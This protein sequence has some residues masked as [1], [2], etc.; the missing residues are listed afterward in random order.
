MSKFYP[1][2]QPAHRE[3]ISAQHLFF[4]G[5]AAQDGRV[6]ISP[7]GNDSLRILND[8]QVVWLNHTG[9]GNETSAHVQHQPRMTI[10]FCAFEKQPLTLRLYGKPTAIHQADA[11]WQEYIALFPVSAGARQL[12]LLDIDSV[13]T[14][15]GMSTP[16]F[17]YVGEREILLP[18]YEKQGKAE[19]Q[20][21]WIRKN[22]TSI[23]G[24][25]TNIA[26]L[27]GLDK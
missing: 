7:K 22:H 12:F 17:S 13:Q 27:S 2:L 9:S 10:M 6:N 11:L 16:E 19:I 20:D 5:T 3:F 8:K 15:C 18:W 23:D 14:S 24:M 25:P 4:V 26:T 1:I 21:Y